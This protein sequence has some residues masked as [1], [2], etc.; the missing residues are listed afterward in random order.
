MVTF[1]EAD[2]IINNRLFLVKNTDYNAILMGDDAKIWYDITDKDR[3]YVEMII[4]C[5]YSGVDLKID[6]G[7]IR[8]S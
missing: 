3:E 8:L 4:D 6:A 2:K 7:L 1:E 5:L